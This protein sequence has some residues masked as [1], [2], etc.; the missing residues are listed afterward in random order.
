MLVKRSRNSNASEILTQ[1]FVNKEFSN[2]IL[3]GEKVLLRDKEGFKVAFLNVE[4]IWE[5]DFNKEAL[6]VKSLAAGGVCLASSVA[7]G[8]VWF[9]L[10]ITTFVCQIS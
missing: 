2:Q 8:A 1:L 10:K 7:S 9:I 4:S 5:P 3:V 6:N